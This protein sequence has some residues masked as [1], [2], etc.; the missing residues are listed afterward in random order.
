M[1]F[2]SLLFFCLQT[3]LIFSHLA[4]TD[5]TDSGYVY[6][7]MSNVWVQRPVP[8]Y[9]PRSRPL[10]LPQRPMPVASPVTLT[11]VAPAIT[12]APAIPAHPRLTVPSY[13]PA[14]APRPNYSS[15]Y[16]P[17]LPPR[18]IIPAHPVV[19]YSEPAYIA[20]P[21]PTLLPVTEAALPKK[22]VLRLP[23]YAPPRPVAT[24]PPPVYVPR[25]TTM[26]LPPITQAPVTPA[27]MTPSSV[28][29]VSVTQAPGIYISDFECKE[30]NGYYSVAHQCDSYIQCKV[31]YKIVI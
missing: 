12:A 15:S 8:I 30:E 18:P 5:E 28:G 13:S 10:V 26:Y 21:P 7:G 20:G 4:V 22:P 6:Y 27:P 24:Q 25:T 17:L 11:P 2:L 16:R 23:T 31:L 14:L 1:V 19:A 29:R 9:G 3:F